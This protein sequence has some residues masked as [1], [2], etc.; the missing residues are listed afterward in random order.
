M[1]IRYSMRESVCTSEI[2]NNTNE[3]QNDVTNRYVLYFFLNSGSV[4]KNKNILLSSCI[5]DIQ[6]L[7]ILN[8]NFKP[9]RH[10][11]ISLYLII[12][13]YLLSSELSLI[14]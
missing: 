2:T 8:S 4:Q 12:F 14:F 5:L 10:Y 6:L 1:R 3:N 9:L 11:S 7:H 13:W